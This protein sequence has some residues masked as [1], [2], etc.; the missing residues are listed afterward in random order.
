MDFYCAYGGCHDAG[1][2]ASGIVLEDFASTK[3]AAVNQ[4]NFFCVIDWTCGP[5]MPQ[6]ASQPLADSLINQI[7]AWRSN[8][9]AE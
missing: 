9:Y 1:S 4:S 8:C 3:S 6:G 7:K 5:K 2:A